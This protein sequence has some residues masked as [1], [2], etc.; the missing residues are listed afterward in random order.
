LIQYWPT[1]DDT[2][3][4]QCICRIIMSKDRFEEEY[5][6]ARGGTAANLSAEHQ[7]L[8]PW[9]L[10]SNKGLNRKNIKG[11]PRSQHRM[12][13]R[14]EIGGGGGSDT[15][16]G[17]RRVCGGSRPRIVTGGRRGRVGRI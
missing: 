14:P 8:E 16:R 6:K 3:D 2:T 12:L 10:W 17:R 9:R 7:A 13:Q 11:R 5:A 1:R 15:A 4:L